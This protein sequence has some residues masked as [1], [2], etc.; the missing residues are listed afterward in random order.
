M[1]K[2]YKKFDSETSSNRSGKPARHSSGKKTGG[3]RT[4]NSYVE[5]D[6]EFDDSP[7]DDEIEIDDKIQIV[8]TKHKP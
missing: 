7:F 1:G 3:M 4:I 8:H 5:E 2:T 6:Y